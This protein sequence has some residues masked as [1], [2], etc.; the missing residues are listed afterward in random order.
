MFL[1]LDVYAVTGGSKAWTAGYDGPDGGADY[2]RAVATSFDGAT[3]FTTG[4]SF[5]A[6]SGNDF[7]TVAVDATTGERLWAMRYD[8]PDGLDDDPA[9]VAVSSDGRAVFVTGT[10]AGSTTA[11]DIATVA[12]DAATGSELWAK[13]FDGPASGDDGGIGIG[14]SPNGGR[15]FVVGTSYTSSAKGFDIRT[16]AY[17]AAS[18]T[19]RW[20]KRYNGTWDN[21]DSAYGVAVSP[22]GS[23]VIAIG[24]AYNNPTGG[25]YATIAYAASSGTVLWEKNYNGYASTSY[26]EPHGAVIN[27]SGTR[28][29]VTGAV[30]LGPPELPSGGTLTQDYGTVVYRLATGKKVWDRFFDGP[31]HGNDQ[32][33][34]LAVSPDGSMLYVT[35]ILCSLGPCL[36]ETLS[37]ATVAYQAADGQQDWVRTFNG[38][39]DSW[40]Q[41]T[42]I[43]VD[44]LD[45][46]VYVTGSMS[47]QGVSYARTAAYDPSTGE[48]QFGQTSTPEAQL[49]LLL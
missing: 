22:D 11:T 18:G 40:D 45:S 48:L 21:D 47:I 32:G 23:T 1:P 4:T 9:D 37:W 36:G 30:S 7:A 31:D 8:G 15:V 41:S 2:S 12:Y 35:G 24:V 44:P 19:E 6:Q 33:V 16:I 34:D 39:A 38:P 26:D 29:F 46:A 49:W 10:S 5:D 17:A 14:A 27:S 13:R 42:G 3:V 20:N 25:D 43:A 28:V